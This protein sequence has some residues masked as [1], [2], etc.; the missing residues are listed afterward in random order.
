MQTF[1]KYLT[2]AAVD[3]N[4]RVDNGASLSGRPDMSHPRRCWS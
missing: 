2:R 1:R 4:L 3:Q